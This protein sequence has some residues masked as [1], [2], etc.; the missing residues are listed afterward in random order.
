MKILKHASFCSVVLL[1]LFGLLTVLPTKGMASEERNFLFFRSEGAYPTFS[2]TGDSLF[3][4]RFT[5]YPTDPV[6]DIPWSCA[7]T[8]VEQIKCAF[9]N[10]RSTENS[11][12]GTFLPPV[13]LPSQATWDGMS[14]GEKAL[15]LINRERIDRGID[16]LDQI[17]ANVTEVAQYY[18]DFLFDNDAWGHYED[19]FSPWERLDQKPAI[20]DCHDNLSVA[21][22]LAVFVSTGSI[23]LPVERSVYMWMYDDAGSAWGHRHAILWYPY[24][25]N[26]GMTGTEG[27]LGIGRANG[28]PYQGPFSNSWPFAEMIVMNVFDP[29]KDWDYGPITSSSTSSPPSSST[30]TSTTSTTSSLSSTTTTAAVS[31][32]TTT[33]GI[34]PSTTTSTDPGNSTSSS[35]TSTAPPGITTTTAEVMPD[36]P[37]ECLYGSYSYEVDLLRKFRDDVLSTTPEGRQLI[38]LYYQL[39]SLVVKTMAEDKSF[40]DEIKKLIDFILPMIEKSCR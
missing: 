40:E 7:Y 11:Q 15:W 23:P 17:E 31:P 33:T 25:D 28:G 4:G 9:D 30:T 6:A 21:E 18:A 14:D 24:N 37:F 1:I 10:A 34:F 2:A 16:P 20:L 26:S 19:G 22:N 27:F 8:G 38:A 12:L 5:S 32:S 35:S 29:C 3:L 39:S 36:C 13:T